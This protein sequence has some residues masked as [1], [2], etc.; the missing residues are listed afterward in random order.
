M[1]ILIVFQVIYSLVGYK[2]NIYKIHIEI[3]MNVCVCFFF[4][5]YFFKKIMCLA[6]IRL[7]NIQGRD[8][9]QIPIIRG[10]FSGNKCHHARILK[11][12]L[13]F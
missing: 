8:H 10:F 4:Y 5:Y 12:N 9:R 1:I 3:K 2:W 11:L 13:R 6:K 7:I